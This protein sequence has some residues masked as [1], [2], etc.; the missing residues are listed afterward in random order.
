LRTVSVTELQPV[1]GEV[2]HVEAKENATRLWF[3][4]SRE[5]FGIYVPD[6]V[7]NGVG[8]IAIGDVVE[9]SVEVGR[10]GLK[11]TAIARVTVDA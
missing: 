3:Q 9:V 6:S 8:T 1:V 10:F 2:V 11:A 7:R 4:G 5:R